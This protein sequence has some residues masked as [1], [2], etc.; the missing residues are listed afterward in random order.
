MYVISRDFGFKALVDMTECN[1][2]SL[3]ENWTQQWFILSKV[4]MPDFLATMQYRERYTFRKTGFNMIVMFIHLLNIF[5]KR[6]QRA[7]PNQDFERYNGEG[8]VRILKELCSG[9]SLEAGVTLGNAAIEL[10]L[11]NL[12]SIINSSWPG[13]KWQDLTSKDHACMDITKSSRFSVVKGI[14]MV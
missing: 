2:N 13:T 3:T 11:Q 6:A 7:F 12:M 5:P 4:E 9:Y 1:S 8:S 10:I 14:A